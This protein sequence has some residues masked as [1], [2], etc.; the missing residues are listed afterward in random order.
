MKMIAK[1]TA[2]GMKPCSNAAFSLSQPF[3]SAP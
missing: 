3:L 2:G 1:L